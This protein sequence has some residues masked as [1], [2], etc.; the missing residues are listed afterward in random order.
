M[1]K[2]NTIIN[3]LDMRKFLIR[4]F[5]LNGRVKIGRRYLTY[6]KAARFSIPISF[7]FFLLLTISG[8]VDNKL[9]LVLLS[10]FGLLFVF[11]MSVIFVYFRL[12][13]LTKDDEK[14]MDEYQLEMWH[15]LNNNYYIVK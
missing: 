9:V 11:A 3:L 13:P 6:S 7:I 1:E 15:H 8:M 12:R 5:T 14:H 2:E 10:I 4:Q